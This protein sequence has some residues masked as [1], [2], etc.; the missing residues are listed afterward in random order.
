LE[1]LG[2]PAALDEEDKK[3]ANDLHD[4]F[5]ALLRKGESESRH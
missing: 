1:K 2:G 5:A 4:F 3:T